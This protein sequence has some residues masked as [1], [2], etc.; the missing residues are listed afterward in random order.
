MDHFCSIK[1]KRRDLEL[2][3]GNQKGERKMPIGSQAKQNQNKQTKTNIY[4]PYNINLKLWPQI[5]L[6]LI[7]LLNSAVCLKNVHTSHYIIYLYKGK[8]SKFKKCLINK[9]LLS[10][11]MNWCSASMLRSHKL[12]CV[13]L[14]NLKIISST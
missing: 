14:L 6:F 3:K 9:L 12:S 7:W 5:T 11:L 8:C 4:F 2:D 13:V 1:R 10:N